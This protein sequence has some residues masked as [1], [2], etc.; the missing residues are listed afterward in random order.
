MVNSFT[1]WVEHRVDLEKSSLKPFI[2]FDADDYPSKYNLA[3][4]N[5]DK[6]SHGQI[7][8]SRDPVRWVDLETR[9]GKVPFKRQMSTTVYLT[10]NAGSCCSHNTLLNLFASLFPIFSWLR[11]YDVKS[12]L[13][14]DIF[15]GITAAALHL[16]QGM[17]YGLLAGVAPINGLYVSFFPVI[18]Y[19]I[20][21]TSRHASVGTFAIASI[22]TRN[23][24][25]KLGVPPGTISVGNRTINH[26]YIDHFPPYT[27]LEVATALCFVAGIIRLVMG[28]LRL[29]IISVLLS[30]QSVSAFSTGA[31]IHVATSQIADLFG[32][33]SPRTVS[34]PFKLVHI[35]IDL[36]NA[37]STTNWVT[38]SL[39]ITVV[40]ILVVYKELIDEP[41][42]RKFHLP[43]SVPVD[44][45]I[46]ISSTALSYFT[47][48]NLN[49]GVRIM[50][51]I[52][53]GLPSITTPN[54]DLSV[55]LLPDG[56][57]VAMVTYA[58]GLSL[59][60]IFAKKHRYQIRP[61]QELLALGAADLVSSFFACYPCSASL[62]R[63]PVQENAG[64]RTQLTALISSAIMLLILLFLGP[65][66]FYLPK[67]VLS[68]IIL[69][70]LKNMLLQ[71]GDIKQIFS[72]SRLEGIC[73]LITFLSTVLLDVDLGLIVG[74][75]VAILMALIRFMAPNVSLLGQLPNTEIYVEKN[76]FQ[77]AVE[78]DGIKIFRFS[79]ALFF[80]NTETFRENLFKF[81]FDCTYF[82]L[83]EADDATRK[84]ILGKTK[85]VI[86][87]CSTIS[88]VDSPGVEMILEIFNGLRDIRVRCYLA[89]CPAIVLSMLERTRFTERI[90]AKRSPIFP[91]THDAVIAESL[92]APL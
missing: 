38:T 33:K 32:W 48:M 83:M 10:R 13:V 77:Q 84:F 49:Y 35:W 68:C 82:E 58:I 85:A 18:I 23:A 8:P 26:D 22:M 78:L 66:F 72:V 36:F 79:S 1:S 31:A 51:N 21:G 70:A 56:F 87:D 9:Y 5:S 24:M 37:A 43:V 47:Q 59:G 89:S 75:L 4:H 57:A 92:S 64:A 25:N 45:L 30:D 40:I 28:C 20:M 17:A 19:A 12:D 81:C 42:K 63:T 86:I 91:T 16:P 90:T 52:P 76:Y 61:S 11:S 69:V 54:L 34:G 65:L 41:L 74:V 62:S 80:L 6:S 27:S 2:D 39:S 55:K 44:L 7:L 53:K 73:Y 67:C 88:Y 3:K 29:G 15:A 46:L 14:N 50:G 71:I 60:K